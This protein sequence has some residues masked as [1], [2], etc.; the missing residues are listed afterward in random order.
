MAYRIRDEFMPTLQSMSL[1]ISMIFSFSINA[2]V[3]YDGS[4]PDNHD[5]ETGARGG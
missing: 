1:S 5:D 3:P 4:Y 2:A